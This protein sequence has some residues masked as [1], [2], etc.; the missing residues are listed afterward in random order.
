MVYRGFGTALQRRWY[1]S[2]VVNKG[3]KFLRLVN[4]ESAA[5]AFPADH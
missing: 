1:Y 5:F 4:H 3:I 2:R